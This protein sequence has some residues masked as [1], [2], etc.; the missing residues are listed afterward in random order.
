[1]IKYVLYVMLGL[2]VLIDASLGLFF[3]PETLIII[4][5]GVLFEISIL[6][7]LWM[8]MGIFMATRSSECIIDAPILVTTFV[9]RSSNI[10][11]PFK[12]IIGVGLLMPTHAGTNILQSGVQFFV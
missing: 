2:M 12:I 3:A 6:M 1:M 9:K 8:I 10:W 7:A 4:N 5:S 11:T